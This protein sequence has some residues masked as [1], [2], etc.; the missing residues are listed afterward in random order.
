MYED[1]PS[2]A[3]SPAVEPEAPAQPSEPQRRF[4]TCRWHKPAE[5]GLPPYCTHR[6]VLP[7]AGVHGFSAE[8]WCPDCAFYKLRRVPR[9]NGFPD[10]RPSPI[11]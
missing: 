8:S 4:T 11:R 9:R 1:I 10:D 7:M 6:E 3:V 2:P 5:A